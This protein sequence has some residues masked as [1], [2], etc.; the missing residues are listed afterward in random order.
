M[1][2]YFFKLLKSS[3]LKSNQHNL[4]S[5]NYNVI[6][7]FIIRKRNIWLGRA[8]EFLRK[9]KNFRD[10]ISYRMEYK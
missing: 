8:I 10:G 5:T 9:Y 6:R 3:K 2:I 4:N 1:W 7:N